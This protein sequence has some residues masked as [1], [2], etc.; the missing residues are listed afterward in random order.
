MKAQEEQG[1]L[2]PQ[3]R[4]DVPLWK[5]RQLTLLE[6]AT[7]L[8]RASFTNMCAEARWRTCLAHGNMA[9]L[10]DGESWR[11]GGIP[12]RTNLERFFAQHEHKGRQP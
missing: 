5:S 7:A 11:D 2:V 8:T 3:G 4:Y 6:P 12:Y 10:F 9:R 1:L